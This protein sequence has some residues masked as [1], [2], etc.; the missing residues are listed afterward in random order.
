M[1]YL[2]TFMMTRAILQKS[3]PAEKVNQHA[4]VSTLP[5]MSGGG[6]FI[7]PVIIAQKLAEAE[8]IIADLQ[9]Q[10]GE[11]VSIDVMVDRLDKGFN[12][13]RLTSE[14]IKDFIITVY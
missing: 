11:S 14:K 8:Q 1:R 5:V 10:L 4:M 2:F 9:A 13:G 6:G 7:S 3:T 12:E